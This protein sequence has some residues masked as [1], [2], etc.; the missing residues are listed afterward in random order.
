MNCPDSVSVNGCDDVR[1]DASAELEVDA[2][3]D[4]LENIEN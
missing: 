4:E 1:V 2:S 3:V